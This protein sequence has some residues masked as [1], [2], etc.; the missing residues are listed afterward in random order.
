M[1]PSF[2]TRRWSLAVGHPSRIGDL[3]ANDER[4]TTDDEL[5]FPE[6]LDTQTGKSFSKSLKLL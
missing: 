5:L 6:S 1:N 4:P 2:E 3:L